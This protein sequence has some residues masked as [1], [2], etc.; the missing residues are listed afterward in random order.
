MCV[1]VGGGG[2]GG[3]QCLEG[4]GQLP[5]PPRPPVNAWSA[6]SSAAPLTSRPPCLHLLPRLRLRNQG[7][8]E[9]QSY[10]FG[11][12][13]YVTSSACLQ[14]PDGQLLLLSAGG[15]GT[16]RVWA[17]EEGKQLAAFTAAEPR[18]R[19]Q[20]EQPAAAEEQAEGGEQQQEGEGAGASDGGEQEGEEEAGGREGGGG[21]G[22]GE[23]CRL[24]AAPDC[25]AVLDVAASPDGCVLL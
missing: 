4:V 15:D 20:Q 9:I 11:H 22:A 6:S 25:A 5:R 14:S 3:S 19:Q 21:G 24:S 7:A 2:R 1:Y 18:P 8:W 13:S 16:V 10:C 23:G 17:P 12:T